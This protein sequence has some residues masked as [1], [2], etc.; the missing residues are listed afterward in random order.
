MAL[1]D[2]DGSAT[3]AFLRAAT[4]LV[5][6]QG[7]RGASVDKISARLNVTKGSFYHHNDNKHD[8]ISEC[9]DRTFAVVRRALS[10]AEDGPRQRLE[11]RLRGRARAGALPVVA[12]RAAAARHRD[13]RAARRDAPRPRAPHACF[14]SP[15]A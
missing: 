11:P 3:E 7:Y 8:L 6:E 14:A 15:S 9:F 4:A 10:L 12:R 2:A 5:N 1:G 13:Q